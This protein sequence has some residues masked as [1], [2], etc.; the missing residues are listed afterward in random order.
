MTRIEPKA[1]LHQYLRESRDAVR[2][3]VDGLSE[4]DVRRPLT[5]S[6]TNLLGMVKHLTMC[7]AGYFGDTFERPFPDRPTWWDEDDDPQADWWATED[8]TRA[9][10]LALYDRVIAHSD[11]TIEALALDAP[12]HVPWWGKG[13]DVTLQ[14]VLVHMVAEVS[15]H[16]GQVDVLREGIDGRTGMQSDDS[17]MPEYDEATWVAYRDKVEQAAR[18][19]ASLGAPPL[20]E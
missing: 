7:E 16:A 17:N 6:G 12:G 8:E 13:G 20:V 19:A 2:W 4:Y 1:A 3:K 9:D 5:P 11:A 10:L 14:Q 15:R 18:T